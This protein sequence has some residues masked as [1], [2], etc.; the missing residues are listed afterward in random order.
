MA[1]AALDLEAP[2]ARAMTRCEC[3]EMAFADVARQ[4]AD[5]GILFSELARRSG[6]GQLCSACLPD[7]RRYLASR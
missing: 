1:V 4:I 6:C 7:L 5:Q 2:I 3:A